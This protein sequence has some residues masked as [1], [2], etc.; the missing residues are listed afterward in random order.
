MTVPQERWI[1]EAIEAV[2]V[3]EWRMANQDQG[4]VP[5]HMA[6]ETTLAQLN[7]DSLDVVE[8]V[9]CFEEL[10]SRSDIGDEWYPHT[11]L[12]EIVDE[13]TRL[14]WVPQLSATVF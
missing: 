1:P 10:D 11:T 4:G 2:L 12:G 8:L 14:G 7:F 13:L 3:K 6:R 5:D 9:M